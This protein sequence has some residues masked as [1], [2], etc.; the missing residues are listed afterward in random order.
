[1]SYIDSVSAYPDIRVRG[2]PKQYL[3]P[4]EAKDAKRAIARQMYHKNAEK[5]K[6][7]AEK[8]GFFQVINHGVS[9]ELL[10]KMKD[11]VRGFHEQS[12]EVRKDFYSRDLTR[13]FQYSSNFDLY[14]SPAANWRDTVA[15]TMDP[16][17]ST[18][19]S[20]DL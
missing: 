10:E 16:D 6:E 2:R 20:R 11:G 9:L 19:Y 3:S 12:P 17:P 1:M 4:E 7:A 5:I 15:C 8:W 18:I 13:K 14:S